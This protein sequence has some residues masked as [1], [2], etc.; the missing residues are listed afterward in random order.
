MSDLTS[1]KSALTV[2]TADLAVPGGGQW[3]M[4]LSLPASLAGLAGVFDIRQRPDSAQVLCCGFSGDVALLKVP[5]VDEAYSPE[6]RRDSAGSSAPPLAEGASQ[7]PPGE[8]AA[9]RDGRAWAV[10]PATHSHSTPSAGRTWS[11][12][13]APAGG[14]GA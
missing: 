3:P 1:L 8:A 4:S 11:A 6:E 10:H 7:Q 5:T 14:A 13:V 2:Y 12:W 9:P